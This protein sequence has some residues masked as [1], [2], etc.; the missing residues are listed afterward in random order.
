[1]VV[2]KYVPYVA[3]S[4]RAMDEY[5]SEIFLGGRNTIVMHNTCEVR[6]GAG[7]W[8]RGLRARP[9]LRWAGAQWRGR[10]GG[11][12]AQAGGTAS[13]G[14]STQHASPPPRA[15]PL[16]AAQDS[17]LA[18]PI[19]MDLVILAELVSR[20]T[21]KK[22]GQEQLRGFHP[23]AVLLSYLTK[24]PLVRGL[25]GRAGRSGAGAVCLL[26]L[27]VR[28]AGA[29]RLA[30]AC[31]ACCCACPAHLALHPCPPPTLRPTLCPPTPGLQVPAG[32]PVVNA[33][34]KQRAM[35]ENTFRACVGL[36][37]E[38][39]LQTVLDHL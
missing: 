6:G 8:R 21:F 14:Q 25:L 19:I 3:D 29:G 15:C 22:D 16:C 17:L 12:V 2:I 27:A 32:V 9:C 18:A 33:L 35:L 4:K 20:I 13:P 26:V 37:P 24:A 7:A 30:A 34:A 11:W 23:V 1:M 39:N 28:G 5:T 38:N 31:R 36:A 10:G